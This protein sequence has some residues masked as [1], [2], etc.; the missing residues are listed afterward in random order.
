MLISE[1]LIP[2]IIANRRSNDSYKNKFIYKCIY[3]SASKNTYSRYVKKIFTKT[4]S[5]PLKLPTPTNKTATLIQKIKTATTLKIKEL[6][7]RIDR[8]NKHI[9]ITQ[10]HSLPHQQPYLLRFRPLTTL[11]SHNSIPSSDHDS[12]SSSSFSSQ[13]CSTISDQPNHQ[14]SFYTSQPHPSQRILPNLSSPSP[15]FTTHSHSFSERL[16]LSDYPVV[17]SR[18]IQ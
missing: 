18:G 10:N 3:Y 9:N 13:N 14:S 17:T 16:S 6:S 7:K 11:L 15:S 8:K 4:S 2:N 12:S 5:R 1:Y